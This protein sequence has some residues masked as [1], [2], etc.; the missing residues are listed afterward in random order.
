MRGDQQTVA[1]L[2]EHCPAMKM[3]VLTAYDDAYVRSLPAA[4]VAGYV[5]KDEAT[6]A[7]LDALR[8]VMR[9]GTWFS[10]RIV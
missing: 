10:R 3:L 6:A 1:C 4:G 8:T 9:G 7:V 5:L 2:R